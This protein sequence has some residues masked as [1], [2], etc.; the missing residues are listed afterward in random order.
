[1]VLLRLVASNPEIIYAYDTILGGTSEE[2]RRL[3]REKSQIV[4]ALNHARTNGSADAVEALERGLEMI[5]AQI[6]AVPA[7]RDP[8]G[9]AR[10]IDD[11]D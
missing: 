7:R 4:A 2:I 11:P 6:D 1:M 9:S 3:K 10:S 5:C 8:Y